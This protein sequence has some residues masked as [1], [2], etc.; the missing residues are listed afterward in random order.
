MLHWRTPAL[1]ALLFAQAF[2]AGSAPAIETDAPAGFSATRLKRLDDFLQRVT[3][4]HGYPGA[5]VLLARDGEAPT[6][7]TY[8]YRDLARTEPMPV[9]AIFRIYSMS[10][11]VTTVAVL[12][13]LEEGRIGLD[14]PI[15]GYLPAF[16]DVRVFAGGTADVPRLRA[17]ARA[18]TIHDLLTHTAG[19]ATGAAGDEGRA[20]L[21]E[22]ADLHAA[23]S[24]DEYVARLARVPLAHDPGTRF[25]YDGMS[26]EPL[27]RLV[28]VVGGQPFDRFVEARILA[29]LGMRD[30][31]FSVPREKRARLV[32]LVTSDAD[33]RLVAADMRGVREPGAMLN[34]YPS[35]AGG[36]YST[37]SDYARFARMLLD[38]GTVNGV[39]LLGRKTVETMLR[40]HLANA[41][42]PAPGLHEGEGFGLGGSVVLDA[43]RR[44]RLA[45]DGAFGWSGAAS[46]YYLIDPRERLVAILLAQYLPRNEGHDLPKINATFHNLVY[47]ALN[48]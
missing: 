27:A 8:G 48:P 29:P 7:R 28:E 15:A 20:A 42:L 6:L 22:R 37:A 19:F 5:V 41:L 3:G 40:N 17:P 18:I 13:L 2:A 44:G 10:K 21:V 47:Q 38:G 25:G 14:D 33:G 11:T 34:A 23:A 12:M 30:T 32:E 39:T 35:G 31:G 16:A 43:T 24:L 4:A 9:D 1:F 26:I 36:L 46:T 45:S